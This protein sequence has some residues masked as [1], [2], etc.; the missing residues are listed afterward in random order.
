MV[1]V[2]AEELHK[3]KVFIKLYQFRAVFIRHRLFKRLR[4]MAEKQI[5]KPEEIIVEPVVVSEADLKRDYEYYMAI[6]LTKTL[7]DEGKITEAEYTQICR[8]HMK[9]FNP[10]L[11]PLIVDSKPYSR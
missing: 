7:L 10:I 6:K 9:V 5:I 3:V 1:R 11:A 4:Q 2:Y 8:Q